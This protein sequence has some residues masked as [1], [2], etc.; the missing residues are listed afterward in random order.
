MSYVPGSVEYPY[1][2]AHGAADKTTLQQDKQPISN[3]VRVAYTGA[4]GQRSK[5]FA[6]SLLMPAHCQ[7][8]RVAK[9][10]EFSRTVDEQAPAPAIFQKKALIQIKERK[11]STDRVRMPSQGAC[12]L[13]TPA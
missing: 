4:H 8:H 12:Y 13:F 6:Y 1:V 5:I 3:Y 10:G 11:H 2:L 9:L 7:M